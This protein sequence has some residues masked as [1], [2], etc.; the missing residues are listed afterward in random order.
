MSM[1]YSKSAPA[2]WGVVCTARETPEL[3]AAFA[4][5]HASLGAS[6]IFLYL[7]EPSP[8]ALELL[9]VIPAVDVTLCDAAYWNRVNGAVRPRRQERR[10]VINAHDAHERCG[11][12]WLLHIDAD[13]FLSPSR[14]LALELSQVPLGIDYLHLQ[15]RERAFTGPYAPERIFD[16]AFRVPFNRDPRTTRL[17]FG[18]GAG[19]TDGGFSGQVSGKSIVRVQKGQLLMGI[20]RPRV[21]SSMARAPLLF[22]ECQSAVVLHFEGLTPAHW[23][24]KISRYSRRARYSEGDLLGDHQRKQIEFLMKNNWCFEAT[25][26]LHSLLKH[27]E[28]EVEVRLRGLGVLQDAAV[29]PSH[30]LRIFGLAPEVDL[31]VECCDRGAATWLPE[32]LSFAA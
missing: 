26:K 4:A 3:L 22:L 12:D 23:M 18:T 28:P 10:Q 17:V 15:M 2:S 6:Q 24:S 14:D 16:G 30:G 5:H 19:F 7:D 9:S 25:Q 21:P 13:E 1:Q 20:H 11:V 8:R 29:D 31:S 32:I 27:V